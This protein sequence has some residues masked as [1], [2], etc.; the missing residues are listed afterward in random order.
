MHILS[1]MYLLTSRNT[2]VGNKSAS[3][4][5]CVVYCCVLTVWRMTR[6]IKFRAKA[7]KRSET[8]QLNITGTLLPTVACCL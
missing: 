5:R 6:K 2:H 4:F 7:A 3:L 8:M 1:H